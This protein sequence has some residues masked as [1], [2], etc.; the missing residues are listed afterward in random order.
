MSVALTGNGSL[1][2]T[3]GPIFA[4]QRTANGFRGETAPSPSS[5]WGASGVA[6]KCLETTQTDIFNQLKASDDL[7]SLTQTLFPAIV[8]ARTSM[9]T[10]FT[11][12]QTLASQ[13]VVSLV[14][15]DT[16]LPDPSITTCLTELIRQ[17]TASSDSVDA[18]VVSTSIAADSGNTGDAVMVVSTK[19][20]TGTDRQNIFPETLL[21]KVMTDG[22]Q[23]GGGTAGREQVKVSGDIKLNVFDPLYPT[24]SAASVTFQLT[25]P[26]D[27]AGQ[28]CLTNSEDFFSANNTLSYW[29]AAN[30]TTGTQILSNTTT[31]V[32]STYS[33][34]FFGDN[35]TLTAIDQTFNDGTN[36]TSKQLSPNT[37]YAVNCWAQKST[38]TATGN[39][40]LSLINGSSNA[41]ITDD[42]GNNCSIT[43]NIASLSNSTFSSINGTFITPKVLP[44]S[45]KFRLALTSVLNTNAS[46]WI[47]ELAMAEMKEAYTEGPHIMG[48]QG[49]TNVIKN[50]YWTWTVSNGLEGWFQTDFD[51]NFDMKTKRLQ[52]PSNSAGAETIVDTLIA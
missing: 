3:L 14:T 33:L 17:M 8:S 30:G 51:R 4:A 6:I 47:D 52:L 35:T 36:G 49:K 43:Q 2:G 20:K 44:S 7:K 31:T 25:D 32:R 12:L 28:N 18:S 50:D 27:N 10:L 11:N 34:Q 16:T 45:Y 40:T 46:L 1:F 21:V 37:L 23:G 5:A 39:V 13:V 48:F 24:G 26:S 38:G 15:A 9:S 42:A 41:T 22:Q 19:G 29:T